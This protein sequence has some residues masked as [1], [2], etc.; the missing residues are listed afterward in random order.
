MEKPDHLLKEKR[1]TFDVNSGQVEIF[2]RDS[3][4]VELEDKNLSDGSDSDLENE[5][6]SSSDVNDESFGVCGWFR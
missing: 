4:L 5:V 1:K 2:K 6:N 3:K